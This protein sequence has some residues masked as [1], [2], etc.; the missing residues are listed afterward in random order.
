MSDEVSSEL[1]PQDRLPHRAPALL[2]VGVVREEGDEL[3]V[4]GELGPELPTSDGRRVSAL[5]GIE[6]AAQ[7]SGMWT[8]EP[9]RPLAPKRGYLVGIRRSE[10]VADLPASEALIVHLQRK[11]SA[12]NLNSFRYEVAAERAPETVLVSGELSTFTEY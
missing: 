1:R 7:A 12:G 9:G 4:R 10:L 8:P 6:L 3:W 11:G 5:Y 2:V